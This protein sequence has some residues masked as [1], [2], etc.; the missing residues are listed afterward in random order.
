SVADKYGLQQEGLLV[1]QVSR[2]SGAAAAG[3]RPAVI[4]RTIWG[5][6]MLQDL[7]DVI[8]TID[9]KKVNSIDDLQ[10]A[11]SD[12]QPGETVQME[13]VR[14]GGHV[15]LPVKLSERPPDQR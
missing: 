7:G 14:Q 10:Q 9:G 11:L 4:R 5:D 12:R 3:L 8:L 13:I 15:T 1:T 2:N 6:A